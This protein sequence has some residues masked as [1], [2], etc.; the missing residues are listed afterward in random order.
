MAGAVGGHGAVE[1]NLHWRLDVSFREDEGRVRT[2][3]AAENDSR[4]CRIALNLLKRDTSV[5]LGIKAKRLHAGWHHEYLLRLI[6][7]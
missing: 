6:S 5:K 1:N 7:Q 4:L 2:G 3:H